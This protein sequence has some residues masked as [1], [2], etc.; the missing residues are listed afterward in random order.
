[1]MVCPARL[2]NVA[3]CVDTVQTL[4]LLISFNR[5]SCEDLITVDD[6]LFYYTVVIKLVWYDRHPPGLKLKSQ[7][8]HIQTCL[9][10]SW[11][12]V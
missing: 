3:S 6:S 12:P 1:M 5:Q 11:D 9:E 7:Y 8:K 2:I 4:G 10:T